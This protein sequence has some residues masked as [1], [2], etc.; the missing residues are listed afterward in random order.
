[1][2]QFSSLVLLFNQHRDLIIKRL[3]KAM[4]DGDLAKNIGEEFSNTTPEPTKEHWDAACLT[5]RQGDFAEEPGRE[6]S[7][8]TQ[9]STK[10]DLSTMY[11]MCSTTPTSGTQRTKTLSAKPSTTPLIRGPNQIKKLLFRITH[12][13]LT[14]AVEQGNEDLVRKLLQSGADPELK[15]NNGLTPLSLAAWKRHEGIVSLLLATGKVDIDVKDNHGLTPLSRAAW[16]NREGIVRLLFE[17]GRAD[18][19]WKNDGGQ[20][21]LSLAARSGHE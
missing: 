2:H 20:T 12:D 17:T 9:E 13:S 16:N 18:V 3:L 5:D 19:N 15:N 4:D 6:P 14:S 8:T 7:N 1:V 11:S 10:N 21:P